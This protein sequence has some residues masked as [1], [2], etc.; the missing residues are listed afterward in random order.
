MKLIQL[1]PPMNFHKIF[2]SKFLYFDYWKWLTIEDWTK[3][4]TCTTT[5]KTKI[6]NSDW[7]QITALSKHNS[8]KKSNSK[9]TITLR[10]F[11]PLRSQYNQSIYT[12]L[13]MHQ[14]TS[15]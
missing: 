15:N 5:N 3:K 14:N 2:F 11:G 6:L 12:A 1:R 10:S 4:T 8:P 7:Q 13:S 9:W